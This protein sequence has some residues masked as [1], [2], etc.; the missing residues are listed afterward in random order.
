MASK[1][2][3]ISNVDLAN[4]VRA[5]LIKRGIGYADMIPKAT[6]GDIRSTMEAIKSFDPQ[7]NDFIEVLQNDIILTIFR[8][9][10]YSSTL[11]M[12]KR[13]GIYSEGSWI[14]EIAF[15][16]LQAH[17]YDK[18][19]TN[20]FGLEEPE[21][22][23]NYHKQNSRLKWKVSIS[24]DMLEQAMYGSDPEGASRMVNGILAAPMNSSEW[25]DYLQMRHL[26]A[27][28]EKA[29]GFYNLQVADLSKSTDKQK[30]GLDI[31]E[32]IRRLNLDMTGFYRTQ[33]NPEGVPTYTRRTVLFGTP[34]FFASF[35]VNVLAAAF[36]MDK[37]NF[38]ASRQVVVD[39]FEIPG[40]QAILADEDLFVCAN[41]KLKTASLYDPDNDI[42]NQW[43]H[44]WGIYSMSRFVNAVRLSTDPDTPSS[45]TVST[46]DSVTADFAEVAG[47]KPT[48]AEAGAS[49][50]LAATVTGTG[51]YSRAVMWT[52]TGTAGVP[53]SSNTFIDGDGKL[54]IGSDEKNE[55]LTVTAQS[56]QD[57]TK[58]GTLKVG[59]GKAATAE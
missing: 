36:N 52:I 38:T 47:V 51:N 17:Q 54:W 18:N 58:S 29:D 7:W 13:D 15:G 14:Q 56:I 45:V 57:S 8:Q 26:F 30:D 48:Y 11:K 28:Y 20:V 59:V 27:E 4:Q 23:V 9:N 53:K 22:H 10:E 19:S 1:T 55:Y 21:I 16:L 41:T 32:K 31:A 40:T 24:P 25:A 39:D 49:T 34:A 46:I 50:K 42:T 5:G 3:K 37:A 2:L 33:Y 35:D 12:F 44:R 43:L 6:Q